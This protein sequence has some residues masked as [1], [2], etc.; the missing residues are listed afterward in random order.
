MLIMF[1]DNIV[2]YAAFYGNLQFMIMGL[3]YSA[4]KRARLEKIMYEGDEFYNRH[5]LRT[6]RSLK[7]RED[8]ETPPSATEAAPSDVESQ[9]GSDR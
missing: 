3:S 8:Q 4:E 5:L 9:K 2:L 1:T 6:S 7:Y